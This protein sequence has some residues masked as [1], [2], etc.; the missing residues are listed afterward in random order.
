MTLRAKCKLKNEDL[1]YYDGWLAVCKMPE[2]WKPKAP[3][4]KLSD[5]R[6]QSP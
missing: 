6:R 4:E 1:P 5:S 2:P 3:N